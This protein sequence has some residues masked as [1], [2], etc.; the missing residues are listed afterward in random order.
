MNV[1]LVKEKSILCNNDIN[2]SADCGT[3]QVSK[4]LRQTPH[5]RPCSRITC[6]VISV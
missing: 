2:I 3:L 4:I 5:R 6:K 1:P